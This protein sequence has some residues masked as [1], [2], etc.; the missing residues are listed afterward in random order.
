MYIALTRG[1]ISASLHK[2]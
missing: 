2:T 1:I